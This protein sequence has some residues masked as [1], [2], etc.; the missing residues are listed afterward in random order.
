MTGLKS[1][2][3]VATGIA[4]ALGSA[5]IVANADSVSVKPGDT[6]SSIAAANHTTVAELASANHISD[7]NL[8]FVGQA[9]TLP[10]TSNNNTSKPS[11]PAQAP[12]QNTS[13]GTYTVKSGDFLSSIAA[14]HGVSLDALASANGISNTNL[15]Y[16]GQVLK[17]PGSGS[18]TTTPTP[19]PSKPT[20]STPT[21]TGTYTIKAGDS[22]WGIADS[23]GMSLNDLLSLNGLNQNSLIFP[24][25]TL[26]TSG[27]AQ[28]P[29]PS[30]PSQSKPAA[31][32]PTA[33]GSYTVKAG[34]SLWGIAN[35]LG[36][37]LADLLSLNGLNQNSLIYPGQ[38]LKTS[39]TAQTPAPSTPATPTP[40]KPA[41]QAPANDG[42][43]E[44]IAMSLV[45]TP[46]VWGGKTP[47]QGFDCSGFVAWVLNHS[48]RTTNF[49]S[50]T[51]SEESAVQQISVSQAQPGDLL[52]WG[53]H[54]ATYHVAIYLGNNQFISAPQPGDHVRVQTL[55]S[56][57]M[58]SF[59]GRV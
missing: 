7:P 14:A 9:L 53:D 22:L 51:V 26:K 19:T 17:I 56:G 30:T 48:G 54:G 41:S 58:P 32:T 25:Q 42:N 44:S 8:I 34:D 33:T 55:Y 28:T 37:S 52:F 47:D 16:V 35:Q 6:L 49:P 5:Q 29:A 2:V 50:Y 3:L 23:L 12:T 27:T 4:A 21:A 57:W 46:Y 38:T 24:G 39:G 18:S 43:W 31:S 1:S 59:A 20:T 45:G 10:G 11:T 15:I 13:G 36:M 40:S